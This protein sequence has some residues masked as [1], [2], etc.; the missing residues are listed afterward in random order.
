MTFLLSHF[1]ATGC[2]WTY[3]H[4]GEAGL[5]FAKT[6]S[7]PVTPV[8]LSTWIRWIQLAS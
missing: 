2:E 5:V 7:L 8:A 1:A 6:Q 4:T 3:D